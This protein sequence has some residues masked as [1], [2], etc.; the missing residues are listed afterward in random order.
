MGPKAHVLSPKSQF[1]RGQS[2]HSQLLRAWKLRLTNSHGSQVVSPNCGM[3]PYKENYL[4]VKLETSVASWV[5]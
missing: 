1:T 2:V 5:E 3:E 4:E